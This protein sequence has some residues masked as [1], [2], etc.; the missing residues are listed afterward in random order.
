VEWLKFEPVETNLYHSNGG[1][2]TSMG[3]FDGIPIEVKVGFRVDNSFALQNLNMNNI[4]PVGCGSTYAVQQLIR[5]NEARLRDVEMKVQSA[6][7]TA[8]NIARRVQSD[9]FD[10][11]SDSHG[12]DFDPIAEQLFPDPA[13]D[14][15]RAGIEGS[16]HADV[17]GL[18]QYSDDPRERIG[19]GGLWNKDGPSLTL[20]REEDDADESTLHGP[21]YFAEYVKRSNPS[22]F[23]EFKSRQR[24]DE[25]GPMDQA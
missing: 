22:E 13:Y 16:L 4:L 15:P 18:N 19:S 25:E 11:D 2:R 14:P 24:T 8:T 5:N 3:I 17:F 9:E 20:F 23:N 12:I 7:E 6:E 10:G 1:K 21:Q